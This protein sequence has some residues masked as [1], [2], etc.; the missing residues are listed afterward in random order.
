MCEDST[1]IFKRNMLDRYMDR[2]DV[3]FAGGKYS[4]LDRFCYAE[5]LSHYVLV[6]GKTDNEEN[7]SQPEI[8][9]ENVLEENH[10]LCGYPLNIP[11]MSSKEKLKCKTVKSVLRYHVPNPHKQPE[12]YGHHMLFMF[13]PFRKESDL[14]SVESGT[15]MEKLCDPVIKNIV[16]E[17]KQKFE[18]FAELVDS[19]L[20]DYRTDLTRNPD[21]FVQQENDEVSA[22]MET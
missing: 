2:P 14:C 7:D 18:P 15:Y 19:A 11:L 12:K 16:N 3:K 17:N 10:S 21:A 22:M 6:S 4:I 5:F 20:T 8:L 9:T 13:Y 1:D